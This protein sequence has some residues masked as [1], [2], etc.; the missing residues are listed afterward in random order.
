MTSTP[1]D[2]MLLLPPSAFQSTLSIY[3]N[4]DKENQ[5]TKTVHEQ[6]EQLQVEMGRLRTNNEALKTSG[7][8]KKKNEEKFFSSDL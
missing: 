2:N 3:S 6:L 7:R 5:T 1:I 4:N 8:G